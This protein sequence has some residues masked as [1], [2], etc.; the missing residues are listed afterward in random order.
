MGVNK[1]IIY[2]R[3]KL[4]MSQ[5]DLARACGTSR[6]NVSAY[7]RGVRKPKTDFA[8]KI[9]KLALAHKINIAIEDFV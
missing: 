5:A 6:Q 9:I 8:A 4:K 1:T 3:E 7:E 2:V